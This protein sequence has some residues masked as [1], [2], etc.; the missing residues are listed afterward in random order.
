[1]NTKKDL[2][3]DLNILRKLKPKNKNGELIEL[4][5]EFDSDNMYVNIAENDTTDFLLKKDEPKPVNDYCWKSL[6]HTQ[7]WYLKLRCY[8]TWRCLNTKLS[9][10]VNVKKLDNIYD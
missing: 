6:E 7:N 8:A 4:T 1:M 3:N 2:D 10:A 5:I 9:R